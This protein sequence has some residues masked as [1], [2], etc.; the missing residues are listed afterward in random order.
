MTTLPTLES[1]LQ[2]DFGRTGNSEPYLDHGWSEPADRLTRM[3]GPSSSL[4]IDLPDAA[5]GALFLQI[6]VSTVPRD[7][8]AHHAQRLRVILNDYEIADH[9]ITHPVTLTDYVP[10]EAVADSS[11]LQVVLAHPARV[12]AAGGTEAPDS[13]VALAVHAMR[14]LRVTDQPTRGLPDHDAP[15]PPPLREMLLDFESLGEGPAFARFRRQQGVRPLDLLQGGH[16][17]LA[18]WLTLL[19]EDFAVLTAEGA[20]RATATA[21]REGEATWSVSVDG[22]ALHY[23]TGMT[24]AARKPAAVEA[25]EQARLAIA[26]RRLRHTLAAGNKLLLFQ[27]DKPVSDDQMIPLLAAVQDR[28]PNTILWVTPA[29]PGHPAGSVEVLMNG[30]LR[31]Y[32]GPG[33]QEGSWAGWTQMC[34]LAWRSWRAMTGGIPQE[35]QAA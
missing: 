4:T 24:V 17:P 23:D 20:I 3:V 31:G 22:L 13:A 9:E 30:L 14:I 32:V 12:S 25:R 5:D 28:G 19:D 16:A 18:D 7:A 21:P 27:Q 26:A 11:I 15:A 2:I 29:E 8:G 10:P 35:S 6:K 34:R 1:V 33:L